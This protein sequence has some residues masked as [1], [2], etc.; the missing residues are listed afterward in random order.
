MTDMILS[1]CKAPFDQSIPCQKLKPYFKGFFK[2]NFVYIDLSQWQALPEKM[3]VFAVLPW[4]LVLSVRLLTQQRSTQFVSHH[5]SEPRFL[6]M[7][8]FLIIDSSLLH[9]TAP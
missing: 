7:I 3:G 2:F 8:K 6:K 1:G 4:I 9:T 5:T